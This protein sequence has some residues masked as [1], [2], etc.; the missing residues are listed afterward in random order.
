MTSSQLLQ[1][2]KE[3]EKKEK[4]D[5]ETK[6]MNELIAAYKG[7]CFGTSK[8]RQKSKTTHHSAIYIQDIERYEKHKFATAEGTIVCSW[9]QISVFKGKD[10]KNEMNDNFRYEVGNYTTHLNNSQYNMFYNMHNLISGRKEIPYATFY[11][12]FNSGEITHQIIEDAFSGKISLEVEKT[13]GDAGNQDRFKKACDIAG[14]KL[15]DLED[16]MLLLNV[17]RYSQLPGYIQDR[18][19]MKD[20]AVL[21]LETQIKLN[22]KAMADPWCDYRRRQSFER[23][24]ETLRIY[25]NKFK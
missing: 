18:W 17:I 6:E 22:N 15:I 16:H 20:M 24:N 14:V 3:L 8:F 12:L 13:M 4:Y 11:E 21:A 10:W 9:Q 5:R 23:E 19:L 2:A 1:Q 25:I 7:K